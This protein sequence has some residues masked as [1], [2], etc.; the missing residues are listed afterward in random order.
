MRAV[1]LRGFGFLFKFDH[2]FDVLPLAW[3]SKNNK[4]PYERLFNQGVH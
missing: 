2:K 1:R 4:T 3:I